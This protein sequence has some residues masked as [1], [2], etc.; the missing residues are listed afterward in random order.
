M[1]THWPA[2]VLDTG[3]PHLGKSL[4]GGGEE[5]RTAAARER[6]GECKAAPKVC[7]TMPKL[8]EAR[9][10]RDEEVRGFSELR[11]GLV[12]RG[13]QGRLQSAKS[14]DGASVGR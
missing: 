14:E 6:L 10:T 11:M 12:T 13:G 8:C 2:V 7:R 4:E 1:W 5:G 9:E 3:P